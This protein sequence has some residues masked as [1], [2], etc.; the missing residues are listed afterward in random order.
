VRGGVR[1]PTSDSRWSDNVFRSGGNPHLTSRFCGV[2]LGPITIFKRVR[3]F[4]LSQE[5]WRPNII[6]SITSSVGSSICAD[7]ITIKPIFDITFGHFVRVLFDI[8]FSVSLK[9]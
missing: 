5:Y 3:V 6:F 9:H 1:S 7:S 2:V 8:D 4:G